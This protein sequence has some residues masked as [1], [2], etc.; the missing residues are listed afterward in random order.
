M[1]LF[2]EKHAQFVCVVCGECLNGKASLV[3]TRDGSVACAK[4]RSRRSASRLPSIPPMTVHLLSFKSCW[5]C[6]KPATISVRPLSLRFHR[7]Y[8]HDCYGKGSR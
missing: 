6:G 2:D 4:H 3:A 8:C 1:G 5:S 7:F